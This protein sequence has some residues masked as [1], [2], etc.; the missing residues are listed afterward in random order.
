MKPYLLLTQFSRCVGLVSG[1]GVVG[2]GVG[3]FF[4]G[5]GKVGGFLI[6]FP[7]T[8]RGL[9]SPFYQPCLVQRSS[10]KY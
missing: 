8:G 2:F 7:E 1:F 9:F 5:G 4:G 6:F 3:F 10:I